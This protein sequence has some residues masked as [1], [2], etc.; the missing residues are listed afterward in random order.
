MLGGTETDVLGFE[1]GFLN[2]TNLRLFLPSLSFSS[3]FTEVQ[4]E[5]LFW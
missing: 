2:V 5:G 3:S 4:E 1:E